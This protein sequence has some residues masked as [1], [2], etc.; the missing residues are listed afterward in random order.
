MRPPTS[1]AGSGVL[2]GGPTGGTT[3]TGGG[4]IGGTTTGGT[5]G[6]TNGGGLTGGTLITGGGLTG[7][8]TVTGGLIGHT[9][10]KNAEADGVQIVKGIVMSDAATNF[11]NFF[12]R[13]RRAIIRILRNP[14]SLAQFVRLLRISSACPSA[15]L[16]HFA[17]VVR[18]PAVARSVSVPPY[19]GRI[20]N[21]P[22]RNEASGK[23]GEW[24]A[25][26]KNSRGEKSFSPSIEVIR[27]KEG[28][29]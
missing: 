9:G 25:V 20:W 6:G 29:E 14:P 11:R 12:K 27:S 2:V 19:S 13:D 7:G 23:A 8:T 22:N 28:G 21:L 24:G 5:T 4:T 16:E 10:G 15:P 26:G 3:I 1:V 17:P 18:F